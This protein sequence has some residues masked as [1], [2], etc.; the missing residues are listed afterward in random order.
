MDEI[1][2]IGA[3]QH[4]LAMSEVEDAHHAGNDAEAENHKHD[5]RPEAQHFK[6]GVQRAFHSVPPAPALG[7]ACRTLKDIRNYL[8]R[9]WYAGDDG[10]VRFRM[11]RIA[12][13]VEAFHLRVADF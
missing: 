7:R 1:G 8:L 11:E 6:D 2:R 5:D 3:Q 10:V 9:F 4:E 13:D 12:A